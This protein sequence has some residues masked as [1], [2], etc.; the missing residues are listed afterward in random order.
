MK[1]LRRVY[2]LASEKVSSPYADFWFSLLIMVEA[3]FLPVPIDPLFVLYCLEGRRKFFYY[4][5]L[6]VASTTV[7]ALIA[8]HLGL[9]AFESV[10]HNLVNLLIS[11]HTF[12]KIRNTY[13]VH[14][15][16]AVFLAALL[17]M[18]FKLISL[19][20]GF[21]KLSLTPFIVLTIVARS[22]R[23]ILW[24]VASHIWG[25]RIK[26]FIDEYFEFLVILFVIK[27]IFVGWLI[28]R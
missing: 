3:I 13:A 14:Q 7:G 8:Y 20:A 6:G 12:E 24:E 17:P 18:P 5:I 1:L 9:F 26:R 16:L 19:S 25:P 2:K 27:I 23:F 4:S 10:G 11:E 15:N 28:S 22:F 21:C